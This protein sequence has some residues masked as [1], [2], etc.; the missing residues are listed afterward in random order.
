MVNRI[1][2]QSHKACHEVK[3][4]F[5][6][7]KTKTALNVTAAALTALA[8]LAGLIA[9]TVFY[10]ITGGI[11]LTAVAAAIIVGICKAKLYHKAGVDI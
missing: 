5:K 2:T 1:Q 7:H 10:P 8:I 3:Q 11:I 9:L 6:S 4:F